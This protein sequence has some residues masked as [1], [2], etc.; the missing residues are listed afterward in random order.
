MKMFIPEFHVNKR[1]TNLLIANGPTGDDKNVGNFMYVSPI[2]NSVSDY[3][4]CSNELQNDIKRFCIGER[5]E[6]SH[7]QISFSIHSTIIPAV[8]E[9]NTETDINTKRI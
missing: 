9:N 4:I 1:S 6:S 3:F 7:F 5:T 8:N 2:G